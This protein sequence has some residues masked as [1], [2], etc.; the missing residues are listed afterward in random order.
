MRCMKSNQSLRLKGGKEQ[1]RL[2][3]KA[4]KEFLGKAL[5]KEWGRE[6]AE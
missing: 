3:G 1:Y 5:R 6:V 4:S 2:E